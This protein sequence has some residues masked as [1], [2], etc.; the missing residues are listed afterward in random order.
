MASGSTPVGGGDRQ[1]VSAVGAH[2][3]SSRE[4]GGPVAVVHEVHTGGECTGLAHC[5][6]REPSRGHRERAGDADGERR[7]G[8]AGDRRRLCFGQNHVIAGITD[9]ER[10]AANRQRVSLVQSEE[11]PDDWRGALD[12]RECLPGRWC[13][14]ERGT[15]HAAT[16][17]NR[18][19]HVE[20]VIASRT[21]RCAIELDRERRGGIERHVSLG[22][23][24]SGTI[25][26]ADR[27]SRRSDCADGADTAQ[28]GTT[29]NRDS[30]SGLGAVNEQRP[31]VHGRGAGERG[32][33]SGKHQRGGAILRQ[34]P[35]A[36][37]ARATIESKWSGAAED[38]GGPGFDRERGAGVRAA[39]KKTERAG[40]HVHG[41]AG[42]NVERYTRAEIQLAGIGRLRE[43]PLVVER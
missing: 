9:L 29:L 18:A 5:G 10:E 31:S 40:L 33:V 21:R 37:E 19:R 1:R 43:A 8:G 23:Q 38:Q 39:G 17:I 16:Q 13:E 42:R 32:A 34:V 25:S 36:G 14:A 12:D 2:V 28:E 11:L 24:D 26:R 7:G 35:R 27:G 3:G 15:E 22:G 41:P 4:T 30:A 6:D 20:L